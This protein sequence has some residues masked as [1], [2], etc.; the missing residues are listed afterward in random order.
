MRRWGD[1]VVVHHALSNDTYRLSAQAGEALAAL[2][3]SGG[4]V[5]DDPADPH[6]DACLV[7]LADLGFVTRC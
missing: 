7:A 5:A 3:T 1:E 4:I 2:T 6:R